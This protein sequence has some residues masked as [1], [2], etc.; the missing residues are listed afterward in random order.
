MGRQELQKLPR[1]C[2]E[3]ASGKRLYS[4]SSLTALL[5]SVPFLA[6]PSAWRW[7][8]KQRSGAL[9]ED[10]KSR[11]EWFLTNGKASEGTGQQRWASCRS[12]LGCG[13]QVGSQNM[14]AGGHFWC[15]NTATH[16][17]Y[18]LH[19]WIPSPF[20]RG[21]QWVCAG[22][23]TSAATDRSFIPWPGR[24]L[25]KKRCQINPP[26]ESTP[27]KGASQTLVLSS[28]GLPDGKD[29]AQGV[30]L[31]DS[32]MQRSGTRQSPS[33]GGGRLMAL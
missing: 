2:N 21:G 12:R 19:L 26:G 29:L 9:C 20:R 14:G 13:T 5:P 28:H 11:S 8:W 17:S 22:L 6:S 24:F 1:G 25:G 23:G 4:A 31:K 30:K 33:L 18:R 27:G 7:V 16:G 10:G 3:K 32:L 15:Q